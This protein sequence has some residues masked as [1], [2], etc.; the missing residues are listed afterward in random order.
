VQ[1]RIR[2]SR[3]VS[4]STFSTV[5]IC[6]HRLFPGA[7]AYPVRGRCRGVSSTSSM[8]GAAQQHLV[9]VGCGSLAGCSFSAAHPLFMVAGRKASLHTAHRLLQRLAPPPAGALCA[10][11]RGAASSCKACHC[12]QPLVAVDAITG[13]QL[14]V[15]ATVPQ[16][17]QE[18]PASS[19]SSATGEHSV[20]Q[21]GNRSGR[22]VPAQPKG[23]AFSCSVCVLLLR[24][25]LLNSCSALWC[26]ATKTRLSR[27]CHAGSTMVP[28]VVARILFFARR[29][30]LQSE[31]YVTL[32]G[33]LP[34]LQHLGGVRS[35]P[36]VRLGLDC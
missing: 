23:L 7:Y 24:Q 32:L 25:A 4:T 6:A 21:S 20:R 29:Q 15:T 5:G 17:F 26:S 14:C 22:H 31:P 9:P 19:F 8:Q 30:L 10:F 27:C 11:T 18:P 33:Y 28:P 16:E 1:W 36:H 12:M 34:D 35:G 2:C 3:T 13:W